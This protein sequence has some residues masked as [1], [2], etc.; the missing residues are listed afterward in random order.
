MKHQTCD[1]NYEEWLAFNQL[2]GTKC[3]IYDFNS[4][5]LLQQLLHYAN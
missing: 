1:Y 3:D 5:I 2:W 4:L